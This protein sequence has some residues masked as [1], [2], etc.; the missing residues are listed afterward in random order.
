MN[1]PKAIILSAVFAISIAIPSHAATAVPVP[2][3]TA[4]GV[5]VYGWKDGVPTPLYVKNEHTLYPIASL[6]KL[7]TAKVAQELYMPNELFTISRAAASTYG[8]TAGIT[9]GAQFTRDDLLKAL[10]VNSS[11][12]AATALMEPVGSKIFL[13][14]M[15]TVLHANKY[16]V[17]SF[18]NPSGLDPIKK[19]I[20]SNRMT[21]YHMTRLLSDIYQKDQALVEIMAHDTVEITDLRNNTPFVLKQTN[22]LYRDALYKDKVIMGKTGLTNLA[23]QNV[24][25]ITKGSDLYDYTSV[26]ILGSKSRTTD[27]KKVLDWIDILDQQFGG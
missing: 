10:L 24:A 9:T 16:T 3:L 27:S 6:T 25:F 22:A 14:R 20:K 7:I 19:T 26:V 4:K 13:D 23:G 5:A 2:T 21:P 17:T 12:D 15:N 18:I 8:I 1:I 11:N